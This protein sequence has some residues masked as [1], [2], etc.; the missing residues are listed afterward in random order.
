MAKLGHECFRFHLY[1]ACEYLLEFAL[2]SIET[3]S[4]RLKMATISTLSACYWRLGRFNDS[5]NFMNLELTLASHLN[6]PT[7]PSTN[8]KLD[9]T[10]GSASLNANKFRIYGNLA[11]A[12]QQLNNHNECLSNYNL[13]LNVSVEMNNT[14]LVINS[15]NSIGIFYNNLK[16]FN[17]AIKYFE[18]ALQC[19]EN[20]SQIGEF[21][22]DTVLRLKLKQLSLIAEF[23][24]KLN[25]YEESKM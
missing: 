2:N 25:N 19:I 3:S 24:L 8:N 21:S 1:T 20:G 23:Y 10:N 4:S 11:S 13:Q 14:Q 17:K 18:E 7:S 22:Q 6:Y 5:I 12:Y 15:L 9:E 16:D